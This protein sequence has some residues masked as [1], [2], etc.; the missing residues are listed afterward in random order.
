MTKV[1]VLC[2]NVA[3]L[4]WPLN[5]DMGNTNIKRAKELA[6]IVRQIQ[7]DPAKKVDIVCF[8][9]FFDVSAK[10]TFILET[11]DLFPHRIIDTRCGKYILGM[12]SGLAIFSTLTL[13]EPRVF[14]FGPYHQFYDYKWTIGDSG[15]ARKGILGVKVNVG[16]SGE[17]YMLTTHMQAGWS[18]PFIIFDFWKNHFNP[19]LDTNVIS[20]LESQEGKTFIDFM[21]TL[22]TP[23]VSGV[24]APTNFIF[25]GDFNTR[26]V[27]Q[28][29]NIKGMLQ[30]LGTIDTYTG[31]DPYDFGHYDYITVP[32]GSSGNSCYDTSYDPNLKVSDHYP[33]I[34]ECDLGVSA[35]GKV[36]KLE[37]IKEPEPTEITPLIN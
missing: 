30:N 21:T 14:P 37:D 24:G 2:W 16:T 7:T 8:Q 4:P 35:T 20:A 31:V 34:G 32:Y 1:R 11:Q 3:Q 33:L 29:T 36:T 18:K 27:T 12:N 28:S 15:L 10:M 19:I 6:G 9:E 23:S 22:T 13:G 17:F 26:A 25:C 5:G